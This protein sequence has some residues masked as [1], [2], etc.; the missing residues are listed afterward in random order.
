MPYARSECQGENTARVAALLRRTLWLDDYNLHIFGDI[1]YGVAENLAT[2]LRKGLNF[3][4]AIRTTWVFQ[5]VASGR[6]SQIHHHGSVED[7]QPIAF[8][9]P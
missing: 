6:R 7:P 5:R 3:D 9:P 2:I 1:F 8:Y 4:L